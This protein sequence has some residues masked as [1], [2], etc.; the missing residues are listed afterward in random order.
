MKHSCRISMR[1]LAFRFVRH[2]EEKARSSHVV[3]PYLDLREFLAD[4]AAIEKSVKLRGV[5]VDVTSVIEDYSNWW[6]LYGKSLR[7]SSVS[8]IPLLNRLPNCF[9]I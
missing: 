4:S 8:Y 5:N 1:H 9:G 6:N 3:D 7:C 2:V